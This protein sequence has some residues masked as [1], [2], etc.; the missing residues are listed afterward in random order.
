MTEFE[1]MLVNSF[2]AY[3]EENGIRAISYRLK[4]HRFTPQFLDVLVDSLNP[5]LYL[6]IECKSISVDKG[7]NALYFSQHFTVDKNGLHQIERIS[8]YLN[9][10]GRRGFLAVELRLGPGHGREAYMIPW[11]ELAKKYFDKDL[12]LTLQE[13]RNFPEIK[14]QG[15]DYRVDPTEWERK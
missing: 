2:N 1:H 9:K 12:K 8:N 6:G 11:N 7:A 10:S 15:K 4:Q 13:I 3:I 5:D 14:R